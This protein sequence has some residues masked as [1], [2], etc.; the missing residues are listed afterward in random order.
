M[1]EVK[2]FI[3]R[4]HKDNEGLQL[5]SE[6]VSTDTVTATRDTGTVTEVYPFM[7]VVLFH[8]VQCG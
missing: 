1:P 6:A 2:D 7:M 5:E 8:R 4:V 3:P